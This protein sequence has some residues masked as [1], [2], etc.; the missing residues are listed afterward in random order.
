MIRAPQLLALLPI[1]VLAASATLLM[2]IVAFRRDHL[3]TFSLT[4]T[5]LLTT[6]GVIALAANE[7]PAA[8]TPLLTIDRY[9]LFF[10]GLVCAAGLVVAVLSFDYLR[11]RRN[12]PE[13]FYLLLLTA[14]LGAVVLAASNHFASFFLGLETLSV[15]LFPMIAYARDDK[16]SLEA[17]M[18][19][20]VL[21]GIASGFLLF[22][23]ALVYAETGILDFPSMAE[24]AMTIPATAGMV[25]ILVALGFKL[26]VA[27]FHL[28][29]ADVYQG[30]SA[31][32]P[33]L[34]A[35]VSK[36]AMLAV[37]LRYG[38][39]GGLLKA[40]VFANTLSVLAFASILIGNLAALKQDNLK[41]LLGYSSIAHMGYLIVALIATPNLGTA[42]AAETL[43]VYLTAYFVTVL[44]ALG[45]IA[46]LS[47]P[48]REVELIDDYVGLFWRRPWAAAILTSA[49][50]SLAGIPLTAGF[51]G[52]FYVLAAGGQASLWL[53]LGTVVA[54]SGLG[55]Y[56]YL[57]VVYRMTC[58]TEPE[59][60]P[61]V[62]DSS[63]AMASRLVLGVLGLAVVILGVLPSGL[64]DFLEALGE[65]FQ[66]H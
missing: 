32:V 8:V 41:R 43:T 1:I 40:P 36:G 2:L 10:T 51:I 39:A 16:L 12:Q 62:A 19:Y 21:S 45:V 31:P 14:L 6:L 50:L 60:S 4:V 57:R 47:P 64:I 22:G 33:A 20:L 59:L 34:L 25:M 7:T 13:E 24:P 3:L 18:K 9:S 44:T 48:D 27:P 54:G 42:L 30:A 28:W 61:A 26:S 37:L 65:S 11:V 55:L 15:S 49:L 66:Q 35:T 23:M 17:A 63:R 53:L 5:S 38:I 29:T 52:K 56:Y 58:P 46:A